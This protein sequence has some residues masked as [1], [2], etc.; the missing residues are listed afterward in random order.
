MK[1]YSLTASPRDIVGRKV[2]TLRLQGQIPA[3]VYGKNV[4]SVSVSVAATGFEKIYKEAGETGLVELAVGKDV[5]PVLVHTLQRDPVSNHLLH[6]EFHQVD[7]KEKVH[8][9]VPLLFTGDAPAV[10]GKVGVLLTLIDEVEV[11]ALPM[12]LPEKLTVDV[13]KLA[14]VNQE[15]KVGEIKVPSGVTV[16][17]DKDQSVVRVGALISKEA[18]AE[19]AAE[20]AAAAAAAAEA[21]A[22]TPGAGAVPT[23]GAPAAEKPAEPV[24]PQESA[25][26]PAGTTP[27]ASK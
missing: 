5:R 27:K 22:A 18:E 7:L 26:A 24:K 8:T 16:L 12:D 19:A 9:K 20:A 14:E 1:K 10:A 23:E 17:T 6:I 13:S 25:K 11:E 3:T 4:K 21:A 15:V 2:K